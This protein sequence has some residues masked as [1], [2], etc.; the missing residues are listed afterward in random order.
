MQVPYACIC[1]KQ[2]LFS[3]RIGMIEWV[4]NTKPLKDFMQ[5]AMTDDEKKYYM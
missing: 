2:D 3:C 5:S 1:I 4:E